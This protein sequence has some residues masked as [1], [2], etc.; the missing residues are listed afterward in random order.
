MHLK[1]PFSVY[2]EN[3]I[4]FIQTFI[5]VTLMWY[6]DK[7]ISLIE[8]ASFLLFN[9]SYGA[10]LL[11]DTFVPEALWQIISSMGV[12]MTMMITLPQIIET[13]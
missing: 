8:K 6:F 3:V 5:I 11:T 9:V 10:F 13:F 12:G 7:T 1:L 4:V 2:G